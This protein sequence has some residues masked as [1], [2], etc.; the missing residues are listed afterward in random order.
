MA[1]LE[2]FKREIIAP[3]GGDDLPDDA[4]VPG[5]VPDEATAELVIRDF[6]IQ[7]MM[8][9]GSRSFSHFLNVVER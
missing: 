9:V 6:V 5:Q 3:K 4:E 1:E 7:C 8:Q 2:G